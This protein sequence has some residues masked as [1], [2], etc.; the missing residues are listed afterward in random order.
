MFESD[1]ESNF[2][3]KLFYSSAKLE[4]KTKDIL[5]Q[6]YSRNPIRNFIEKLNFSGE[7]LN[8]SSPDEMTLL[9]NQ[10]QMLNHMVIS[11]QHERYRF[12]TILGEI[13]KPRIWVSVPR[14]LW[15]VILHLAE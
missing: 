2:Y 13:Q 15:W 3:Y 11:S 6:R 4:T 8:Y 10:N 1:L 5:F 14:V 7:F 12:I 9:I